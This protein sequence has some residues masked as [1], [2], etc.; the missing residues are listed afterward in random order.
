MHRESAPQWF[1]GVVPYYIGAA[2]YEWAQAEYETDPGSLL[3][4]MRGRAWASRKRGPEAAKPGLEDLVRLIGRAIPATVG[5]TWEGWAVMLWPGGWIDWHDHNQAEIATVTY[6][7]MPPG[8]GALRFDAGKAQP[9]P[10]D[11]M[12]FGG[13]VRHCVGAGA[14]FEGVPDEP[15][16]S[17]AVNFHKGLILGRGQ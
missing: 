5:L 12:A 17:V 16:I 1:R 4:A 8:A 11:L 9:Q 3:G 7:Q 10:G 13:M 2:L 14:Q 6:I 15:R